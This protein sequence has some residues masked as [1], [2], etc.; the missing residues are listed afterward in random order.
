M[1]TAT[2]ARLTLDRF[3]RIGERGSTPGREVRGGVTTVIVMSYILFLNPTILSTATGGKGPDFAAT[4]TMTAFAAGVMTLA[5]G[6]YANYPF[7]L[8]SGLGINAVVAFDF[9]LGR[10]LTWQ[11]AMG[12]VFLEGV[13]ITV[14]VLAGFRQAVIDAIPLNLKRSISVGIGLFILFIGLVDAGLVRVPVEGIPIVN[15]RPAGQPAPPVTLGILVGWPIVVTIV[16]LLLTV[17][18]MARKVKGALLFG[19]LGAT[20]FGMIAHAIGDVDISAAAGVQGGWPS[21]LASI[22][23]RTFGKG[24]NLD[25]FD[26]TKALTAI[27]LIF[28]IML[29]DFFDTMGTVI[30]IGEQAGWLDRQGRLPGVEKVLLVDSV[31]AG[32]GGAAS[33]S[34]V[35]TYIESAAGV[36]E[37]ART[38]LASVVTGVLFLAAILLAPIAGIVPSEA[39][40]PAL[41]VVG[42]LM[43]GG[44][45]E[46]D[47]TT[48]EDGLPAL[49]TLAVMPFTFSITN[50]IGAGFVFYTFLRIVTGRAREVHWMMY[51]VSAAFLVYFALPFIEKQ[52]NL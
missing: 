8:A 19:I 40:A 25:V 28:T 34:S 4:V 49:L 44:L 37:G 11:A 29:S 9:I 52:F 31:A 15:G 26:Q 45:R 1:A 16:G 47:F 41:I 38:G 32:F 20:A 33:A 24:V 17:L 36:S 43:A 3:F 48:L 27:L 42:F 10:G 13:V 22:S 18:L 12:V 46:I 35:T 6:L 23:F 14:L 7:A 50:G 51:V 39:T 5:M 2:S 30:G 21:D